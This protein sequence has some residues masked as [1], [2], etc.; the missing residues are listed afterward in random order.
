MRRVLGV[1]VAWRDAVWA[2]AFAELGK[3]QHG[4][5]PQPTVEDFIA[6]LPVIAAGGI[7]L[8][9]SPASERR[10]K[11][12]SILCPILKSAITPHGG[13]G[14]GCWAWGRKQPSPWPKACLGPPDI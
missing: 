1:T 6:E 13:K 11:P 10:S 7:K 14:F 8:T 2:H 3:V 5:R 12:G 9:A 4:Q